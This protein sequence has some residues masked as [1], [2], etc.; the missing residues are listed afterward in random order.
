MTGKTFY[1]GR[2]CEATVSIVTIGI[3]LLLMAV[4]AVGYF[5]TGAITALIPGYV[6]I[7]LC[8][9]G[10]V[11][12]CF[13]PVRKH[14][15][16]GAVLVSLIGFLLAAVRLGM[17]IPVAIRAGEIEHPKAFFALIIMALLCLAHVGLC[18]KSFV[19][20]R[21]RRKQASS[22]PT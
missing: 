7:P 4:G 3:G 18:A 20:A 16:H 8:I 10:F 13:P 17:T 12:L 9:L 2:I 22:T 21:R 15:M 19:D 11:G 1:A 6:G 14:A 5:S